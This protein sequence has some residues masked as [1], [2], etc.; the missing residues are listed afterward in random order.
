MKAILIFPPQWTPLNPH[1]SLASLYSQLVDN[2]YK[3]N[4]R[5]LNIEFYDEILKKEHLKVCLDNSLKNFDRLFKELSEDFNKHQKN[6]VYS[7]KFKK[8]LARYT[9]IKEAKESRLQEFDSA[10]NFVDEAVS[11][12]RDREKFYNPELL[13]KALNIIDTALEIASLPFSPSLIQL[14]DYNSSFFQLTFESIKEHCLDRTT[15]MFYEFYERIIPDLFKEEPDFIAISV[16]SSSQIVPG[17]TLAMLLKSQKKCHISIGGNFWGRIVEPLLECPE[18]FDIF[19]DSITIEEGEKPIVEFARY[20]EGKLKIED[21]PNL[22]YLKDNV[23]RVN[24][25]AIP[26]TLNEVHPPNL[27]SFPLNLYLTPD[28]VLSVQSSRGCYWKKC[29]FC[30]QDFG[31]NF[32]IKDVDNFVNELRYL[33]KKFN[34]SH[35]EFIDESVSPVYLENLSNRITEENLNVNWFIN[36]RLEK[37]FT[38][39]LL[40]QARNAGLRMMLWGFESGS[41]RVMKLINK[42]IDIDKRFEILKAAD[43]ADIWNFAYIFF[44]FPSETKEEALETIKIIS[45]NT[46]LISSYGRSIFTL[47]KH[48]KLRENPEKFSITRILENKEEFSPS[49]QFETSVGMNSHEISEMAQLCT[50]KC[51][52]AYNNPLWMY[53][54]YREILFLYVCKYGTSTIKNTKV[55]S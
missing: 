35:F 12:M 13:I 11:I 36:A 6:G 40:K 49:Y 27:E 52:E 46:D 24:Q 47:G 28:V 31:Q 39:E 9:K 51:N 43:D 3:V 1:F 54:R 21:V 19:A 14:H 22:M 50:Q 41:N 37:E 38:F 7:E 32:S 55:N 16:N 20:I 33:N 44:G 15:N 2:G 26:F 48:T 17:L 53:L 4:L 5:D 25:K 18:F 30:D 42:G 34:I 45:E 23:V 29:S 10:I 8:K